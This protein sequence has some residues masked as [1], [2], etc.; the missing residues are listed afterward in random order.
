MQAWEVE[1]QYGR[2]PEAYVGDLDLNGKKRQVEYLRLG[3]VL[4]M[5]QTTDAQAQ[6]GIWDQNTRSWKTLSAEYHNPVH[7]AIQMARNQV[8]PKLVLLPV[9][10]PKAD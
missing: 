5:Y 8:A 7:T 2:T 3:R 4:W 1:V 6:T 9:P 10:A